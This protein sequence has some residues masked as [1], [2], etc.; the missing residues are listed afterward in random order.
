[1]SC[2]II[3]QATI[4]LSKQLPGETVNTT[5]TVLTA[6]FERKNLE[7]NEANFPTSE[8]IQK[9]IKEFRG[10]NS[11]NYNYINQLPV[12]VKG[13][14]IGVSIN[15]DPKGKTDNA[16]IY[17]KK[18]GY[19]TSKKNIDDIEEELLHTL[20]NAAKE[21]YPDYEELSDNNKNYMLSLLYSMF[22]DTTKAPCSFILSS[23]RESR[24]KANPI[25]AGIFTA[26][27][28][29][30]HAK[31]I[32]VIDTD[33][34]SWHE[35]L[36]NLV[37]NNT[38]DGL[39]TFEET[40]ELFKADK[41]R[42][43]KLKVG[44]RLMLFES[45]AHY[46]QYVKYHDIN[47]WNYEKEDEKR[48][49]AKLGRIARKIKNEGA[50]N[51][52]DEE[53]TI[54]LKGSIIGEFKTAGSFNDFTGIEKDDVKTAIKASILS[55]K[56]VLFAFLNKTN[57]N[58]FDILNND[59][60]EEAYYIKLLHDVFQELSKTYSQ[61]LSKATIKDVESIQENT[62]ESPIRN[63]EDATSSNIE[64]YTLNAQIDKIIDDESQVALDMTPPE[65]L[66]RVRWLSRLYKFKLQKLVTELKD[67]YQDRIDNRSETEVYTDA[68]LRELKYDVN[69]KVVTDLYTAQ[70]IFEEVKKHFQSYLD[71]SEEAKIRYDVNIYSK[72]YPKLTKNIKETREAVKKIAMPWR[73]K[74]YEKI[75]DNYKALTKEAGNVVS[76]VKGSIN[77]SG[78][79]D[80][81]STE[82][83]SADTANKG[84]IDDPSKDSSFNEDT[85]T[86][87]E[88]W[89]L[90]KRTVKSID[91]A[92]VETRKALETLPQVLKNG[93][94]AYDDLLNIRT[95]DAEN[96]H[97]V[98]TQILTNIETVDDM[99]NT[100]KDNVETF[101]W[102]KGLL[103]LL[104]KDEVLVSKLFR[105]MYKDTINMTVMKS[106]K[107]A[108]GIYSIKTINVNKSESTTPLI[109]TWRKN[110]ED[111]AT[112]VP[113]MTV[114][115]EQGRLLKENALNA[116]ESTNILSKNV[117]AQRN[118]AGLRKVFDSPNFVP[119]LLKV[120]LAAGISIDKD[121]LIQT[122]TAPQKHISGTS[123]SAEN[124]MIILHGL[125][126]IFSQIAGT[127]NTK[128]KTGFNEDGSTNNKTVDLINTFDSIYIN[129]ATVLK[130]SAS[131]AVE[132]T[133]RE[134]GKS[135]SSHS[136]P[137]YLLK[138]VKALK[139]INNDIERFNKY[140]EKEYKQYDFF[141]MKNKEGVGT[142]MNDWLEQ[143]S[144][145]T[146]MGAAT[147]KALNHHVLLHF[148]G[149][150]YAEWSDLDYARVLFK[151]Y[152]SAI[153]NAGGTKLANFYLPLI[154]DAPS[155]EFITMTR[156]ESGDGKTGIDVL[157]DKFYKLA[158][159]EYGRINTVRARH[160]QW[161][162]DPSSIS[163]QK[164]YDI[165]GNKK[166][167]SEFKF[168][169][170]LNQ[171]RVTQDGAFVKD[172][173]NNTN[174]P[175]VLDQIDNLTKK[176]KFNDRELFI[177]EA[178]R[179]VLN[180]SFEDTYAYWEKIGF[181]DTVGDYYKY[182]GKVS[183]KKANATMLK[184]LDEALVVIG[185]N[186][187]SD[188][189]NR[190]IEDFRSKLKAN[191]VYRSDRASGLLNYLK[192]ILRDKVSNEEMNVYEKAFSTKDVTKEAF[193][194]YFLNSS[195]AT[196][197]IIQ[198]TT[199]D[200]AYYK[201]VVDFQKRFK[202]V[203]A[204][205]EKLNT[206]SKYGRKVEKTIY[207]QDSYIVTDA[208]KEVKDLLDTAVDSRLINSVDRD[209]MMSNMQRINV[210]DAQAYRCL[211]SLRAV[212]DMGGDWTEAMTT[213][214]QHLQEGQGKYTIQDF[215]VIWQTIKPYVFTQ[216]K[217]DSGLGD[218]SFIK[219]PVQHKN[220]EFLLLAMYQAIAGKIG[221]SGKL[222]AINKFME[223]HD[224][225]VVQF[226]SAVKVGGHG[227]V[228]LDGLHDSNLSAQEEETIV[229]E[230][231][232]KAVF[233]NGDGNMD[234][235]VVHSIDYSDY[236]FQTANPEHYIDTIQLI[237]TQ[238]KKLITADIADDALIEID[239]ESLTK[240]GWLAAY[241]AIN[242][243]NIIDKFKEVNEIFKD[244]KVLSKFLVKEITKDSNYDPE[245][246]K[247]VTIDPSTGN[248]NIPLIDPIITIKV[249][250]LLN[251][252]IK[253]RVTKQKI[254]GGSLMQVTSFGL[255]D[256]LHIKFKDEANNSIFNKAEWEGRTDVDSLEKKHNLKLRKEEFSTYEEYRNSYVAS[257]VEYFECYLPAYSRKLYA[258]LIN[259]KTGLLEAEKL[260]EEL[261]KLIGYRIPTEDKYSM[262][263][264]YIKGFLPQ[265]NGSAIMLPAEITT[266]AGSGF[267]ADKM[268]IMRPEFEIQKTYDF[269]ELQKAFFRSNSDVNGIIEDSIKKNFLKNIEAIK[270]KT[271]S[272]N[273]NEEEMRNAKKILEALNFDKT[274]RREE[275]NKFAKSVNWKEWDDTVKQRYYDFYKKHREE[276]VID[277]LSKPVKI[278]YN[279][280][281]MAER[282]LDFVQGENESDED[283]NA[284]EIVSSAQFNSKKARNN[285]IIDL[286]WGV[287]T[288]KDTAPRLL[289]PSNF[290][291]QQKIA[292]ILNLCEKLN[293]ADLVKYSKAKGS[294]NILTTLYKMD[295]KDL[296]D[297]E[298]MI[299]P[300]EDPLSIK[301]QIEGQQRNMTGAALIGVYAVYNA[302]HALLQHTNL[303]L[304][305]SAEAFILAGRTSMS[306]HAIK[307]QD[308]EYIT[309]LIS[310]FLASATDNAKIPVLRD[311][312]QNELTASTSMY[313]VNL[314]FSPL[315][316]GLVMKQP[317]VIRAT[318]IHYK[319]TEKR[320]SFNV[321]LNMAIKEFK[322]K[323]NMS[324]G[325]E[326]AMTSTQK[327]YAND[328]F[329]NIVKYYNLGGDLTSNSYYYRTQIIF[330]KL[331]QKIVRQG[332]YF[333]T[334]VRATSF[335]KGAGPTNA[336][337]LMQYTKVMNMYNDIGSRYYPFK[338]CDFIKQFLDV[339]STEEFDVDIFR[340]NVL[341]QELPMTSADYN[342]GIIGAMML[343]GKYFPHFK[344][345]FIALIDRVS[346]E[347]ISGKM[348]ASLVN[349]IYNEALIYKATSLP[350][351]GT[352][353]FKDK[354]G[355]A[356]ELTMGAKRQDFDL[357]FYKHYQEFLKK[358]PG[359]AK[360]GLLQ[361]ISAYKATKR[362]PVKTLQFR[363]EGSITPTLRTRYMQEWSTLL[364]MSDNPDAQRL[365]M[366][367]FRYG[368]FRNGFIFGPFTY[369]QMAPVDVRQSVPGYINMLNNLF[370]YDFM[371][372]KFLDQFIRNH[373]NDNRFT[374]NIE[375]NSSLK[376]VNTKG[377]LASYLIIDMTNRL[378]KKLVIFPETRKGNGKYASRFSINIKKGRILTT[379]YYKRFLT[380]TS[381]SNDATRIVYKRIK[382]LGIKFNFLEYEYGK[383]ADEINSVF[384]RC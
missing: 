29:I 369:M 154:S 376:V 55:D 263:P 305:G 251:S 203:Y 164:N 213:A 198:L 80:D 218:N 351:F 217:E 33:D 335:D 137:C 252:I 151:E 1:M 324:K 206:D 379:L 128:I 64:D 98:L 88:G 150:P 148:D 352:E 246:E 282:D 177:K 331:M 334:I 119:N 201:N 14:K 9:F 234:T 268:F 342:L 48:L 245:L 208:L 275:Y 354:K 39:H 384:Q 254:A 133:F 224:I 317:V 61:Y 102:I 223:K 325:E 332:D 139:N 358:Y 27:E 117:R 76:S 87:N 285:K 290:E 138:T 202:E 112:L 166:G 349:S 347:L 127:S 123:T 169:A 188:A 320:I 165:N 377:E 228:V 41:A 38:L 19:E 7:D 240:K 216:V 180:E 140:I 364:H 209:F 328:L 272:N 57:T 186:N 26:I 378:N 146:N 124:V 113:G 185:K 157:I 50:A 171:L 129:I 141:F 97:Y 238:I 60:D 375:N 292:I 270:D 260:P 336:D 231:L 82:V 361:R 142:W 302:A 155:S 68:K 90:K 175:L 295:L 227:N 62:E 355:N 360:M 11:A 259:P 65:R 147:R 278:Q 266:I 93:K 346:R 66:L 20:T 288:N 381:V 233:P 296:Q 99:M 174:M 258:H 47:K 44:N 255:T 168:L 192:D 189:V 322:F 145:N 279:D 95:V 297:L 368:V 131:N 237:G 16:L 247:A 69:E 178:L 313:L 6:Y 167:G 10:S 356:V 144:A 205:T 52:I 54:M 365:A 249:Q 96:A 309:A 72:V 160:N 303:E 315:V 182:F 191:K 308:N 289:K 291:A 81:G 298:E 158:L 243:E 110:Y 190:F 134:G 267:D 92:S 15:E 226:E 316:I 273:L 244:K 197:Q 63:I 176:G 283:F 35:E 23:K 78:K 333:N 3:N 353:V 187:L 306:L 25:K 103:R 104:K 45:V 105:D 120:M 220:S 286:M 86:P 382:P 321:A 130:V 136:S 163:L 22:R 339:N 116:L 287:L 109:N 125:S 330:G 294:K 212:L 264:I 4:D 149:K 221:K 114:Y 122:V 18:H 196:S 71:A 207:I 107:N 153:G 59:T 204:S 229:T 31:N 280:K 115:N 329:L 152:N 380:T 28:E 293:V 183:P 350:F 46:V 126:I 179:Y 56:D 232:E 318:E 261:R 159:Q 83:F 49:K 363:N 12:H 276:Y 74:A 24:D 374:I 37:L 274:F 51:Q 170:G 172:T 132:S 367:L 366:N 225:D 383:N 281:A 215:G 161:L 307:N 327:F 269:Y 359:L 89:M 173:M 236:G 300:T 326:D 58:Y 304:K 314:G 53:E 73:I 194:L 214:M 311:I 341:T 344:S 199:T 357:N 75:I 143:L 30:A 91:L 253:N 121:T 94:Y 310:S 256:Q 211:S 195:Y 79:V 101:T 219:V 17:L 370:D 373:L 299:N 21:A 77:M 36:V 13:T 371:S 34:L 348:T 222:V 210:G 84:D 111:G 343:T 135:Y 312:N 337:T 345:G 301:T 8:V 340:R 372:E 2:R 85:V 248:F 181:L 193:K 277:S 241:N 40:Y 235:N 108:D 67:K 265:Q 184:K 319:N 250:S 200:L 43:F 32:E 257:S 323:T 284:R 70:G 230:I 362:V 338:G 42:P 162:K 262:I 106:E 100:L 271:S 156:Y 242:T 5:N 239:G 118:Q